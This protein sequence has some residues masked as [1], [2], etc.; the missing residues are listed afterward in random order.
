[1]NRSRPSTALAGARDPRGYALAQLTVG[2]TPLEC[3]RAAAAAGFAGVGLR[4]GARRR[5]ERYEGALVGDPVATAEVRAALDDSGMR[6]TSVCG[7]QL[8]PDTRDDDLDALIEAAAEL[9]A[10]VVATQGFDPD[11]DRYAD[12]YAR[13]A[14][15]ARSAGMR[16][17]L[18]WMA[19]SAVKTLASALEIV[20]RSTGTGAGIVVDALHADRSGTTVE[21]IARIEP[22]RVVLAHWCDARRLTGTATED[23]LRA[24][25]R[26]ARLWPGEGA[27]PLAA[28]A[29]ALPPTVD[30]E[31]EVVDARD[32]GEPPVVRA[33]RSRAALDRYAASIAAPAG[34]R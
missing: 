20:G 2:G 26:T 29:R 8:F 25:A 23:A 27:L 4:I 14:E 7:C 32:A 6:L 31:L 5:D 17:G 12:R 33:R 3:V 10:P 24:E 16:I 28:L 15:S 21:A 30:I 1:M 18:E 22:A 9:R 19:Y 13:F 34:R 11:L